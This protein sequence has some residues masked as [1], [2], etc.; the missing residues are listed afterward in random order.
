MVKRIY[1]RE[2]ESKDYEGIEKLLN[3]AD[4]I[5]DEFDFNRKT[6]NRMLK[7]NRGYYF[8]AETKDKEIVGNI[9][10]TNDGGY[11]GFIY[12]M[13]VSEEYR[14]RKIGSRMLKKIIDKLDENNIPI[15]Y[16]HVRRTNRSSRRVLRSKGFEIMRGYYD[17]KPVDILCRS[18]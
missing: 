4:L 14:G 1:L 16:A 3:E 13:A 10:A 17:K 6:F 12:K 7:K 8:V 18:K 9:F 5:E 2:A 11:C 15:I